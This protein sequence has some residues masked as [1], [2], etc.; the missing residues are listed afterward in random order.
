MRRTAV[1]ALATGLLLALPAAGA[2]DAKEGLKLLEKKT[3]TDPQGKALK[4]RLL[5][6]QG[7][8]PAK[9]YPLVVFLHGAGGPFTWVYCA[10]RCG[11]R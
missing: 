5:K 4:Y 10:Q 3:Y 1:V 7:Y 8:D 9:K 11:R 6:P 2:D